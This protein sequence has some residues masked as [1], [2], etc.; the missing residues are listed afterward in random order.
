[1]QLFSTAAVHYSLSLPQVMPHSIAAV[2]EM[3]ETAAIA[4]LIQSANK[5][6]EMRR[7]TLALA[8]NVNSTEDAA[9][10]RPF[11]SQ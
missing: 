7:T 3:N 4:T 8:P 10:P 5:A 11:L 1:M 9:S 6:P 2:L